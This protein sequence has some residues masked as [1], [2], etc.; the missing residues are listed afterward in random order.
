MDNSKISL[1]IAILII[2]FWNIFY[3]KLNLFI[4]ITLLYFKLVH[5]DLIIFFKQFA[6][7]IKNALL[8][9]TYQDSPQMF[10]EQGEV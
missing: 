10:G 8:R 2:N 4:Q 5:K 1:K 9:N 7:S 6:A 3:I